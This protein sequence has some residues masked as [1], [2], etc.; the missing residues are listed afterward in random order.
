MTGLS[1]ALRTCRARIQANNFQASSYDQNRRHA[2][3]GEAVKLINT[4]TIDV[5]PMVTPIY[6][7]DNAVEAFALTG[8]RSKTMKVQLSFS[9]TY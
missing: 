2:G 8:D 4:G 9:Q 3:F 1:E 7:I 5:K 6:P